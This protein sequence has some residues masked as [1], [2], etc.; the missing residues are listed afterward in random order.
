[1]TVP[2]TASHTGRSK[3]IYD[4]DPIPEVMGERRRLVAQDLAFQ[5]ML[6]DA[7]R[8]GSETLTSCLGEISSRLRR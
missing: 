3:L 2:G 5:S 6:A 1:M 7:L 8:A 4:Q